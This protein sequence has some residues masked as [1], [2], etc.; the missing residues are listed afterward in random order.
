MEMVSIDSIEK[1]VATYLDTELMNKLP[2]SG[3]QRVIAGTAI[4]LAIKKS[5]N[6]VEGLKDDPFV[7]ML[8]IMDADGNVDIET[9]KDEV[10]AQFP[11]DGI[12]ADI[13]MIGVVTFHKADIDKLYNCIVAEI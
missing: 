9:L 11:A 7:K 10:K 6:I 12:K 13:P 3:F 5:G 4:S 2:Q 1:G 8:E